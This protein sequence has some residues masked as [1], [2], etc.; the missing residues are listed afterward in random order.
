M[1]E[2]QVVG[3]YQAR[4]RLDERMSPLVMTPLPLVLSGTALL[5]ALL[6]WAS[7][8]LAR[9]FA[10]LDPLEARRLHVEVTPRGGGLGIAVLAVVAV[11]LWPLASTS[12]MWM[13]AGL[14]V[15]SIV[16][17]IDDVR[18]LGAAAKLL[19]QAVGVGLLALSLP[20]SALA[21]TVVVA[22]AMLAVLN[23]WNF[24]DGSNGMV[25]TQ[26][27]LVAATLA[28]LGKSPALA[29]LAAACLGFLPFNL[30]RARVFL[31]DIG[32]HALGGGLAVAAASFHLVGD[33]SLPQ[34]FV[35]FS[36]F[37]IDAGWT[38]LRRAHRR[39][40]VWQ[41]H[42]QHLYQQAIRSGHSHF[43]VCA[44]YAAWTLLAASLAVAM[45]QWSPSIQWS[46]AGA[47]ILSGSVLFFSAPRMGLRRESRAGSPVE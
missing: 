29:A 13:A 39:E 32:S 5:S 15:I 19:G 37:L 22:I 17:G 27:L 20:P 9:R 47:V 31:G 21:T 28:C 1:P 18:P 38:L 42:S 46:A 10:L 26:S 6:T 25:G 33:V 30:L 12:P 14:A 7:M 3:Q 44:W 43:R 35:L 11:L 41:A 2:L 40:P 16:G 8:R 4:A 45:R 36:A 23:I 24:M 34:L